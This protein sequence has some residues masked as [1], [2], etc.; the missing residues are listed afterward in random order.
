MH[1]ILKNAAVAPLDLGG[2]RGKSS[3]SK[4][5]SKVRASSE[6]KRQKPAMQELQTRLLAMMAPS[7]VN[8]Q[9][10]PANLRRQLQQKSAAD[11]IA[12]VQQE[13]RHRIPRASVVAV[14]GTPPFGEMADARNDEDAHSLRSEENLLSHRRSKTSNDG[15]VMGQEVSVAGS[16]V[17]QMTRAGTMMSGGQPSARDPYSSAPLGHLLSPKTASPRNAWEGGVSARRRMSV[18]L[19]TPLG[20]NRDASADGAGISPVRRKSI[21]GGMM[22]NEAQRDRWTAVFKKLQDEGEIHRDSLLVAMDLAGFPNCNQDQIDKIVLEITQYNTMNLKEFI[23]FVQTYEA[24]LEELYERD[25]RRFDADHS[26][27]LELQ[28]LAAFL[29]SSG[30][31]PIARILR[32]LMSEVAGPNATQISMMQFRSLDRIIRTREGWSMDD[33][34]SFKGLFRRF[35]KNQSG[36]MDTKELCHALRWLGYCRDTE[37][38]VAM[39]A[40]VDVDHSGALNLQELLVCMRKVRESEVNLIKELHNA[41]DR[42]EQGL[43]E[44]LT[45]LKALGY[46]PGRL[47]VREL[48]TDLDG[49]PDSELDFDFI[50]GVVEDFRRQEGFC[51][52]EYHELCKVF[53]EYDS[54]GC[55]NIETIDLNN[56]LRG[57]GY[58]T[59]W[60]LQQT[61]VAEVDIDNSGRIS[62]K[63]FMKIVSKH[64]EMYVRE[65]AMCYDSLHPDGNKVKVMSLRVAMEKS[66]IHWEECDLLFLRDDDAEID[67]FDLPDITT[68]IHKKA[69]EK[70]RTNAGFSKAEVEE[71]RASFVVFDKDSSG[72]INDGELRTL[73]QE[74]MPDKARD[75]SSRPAILKMLKEVD[76]NHDGRLDFGE[77]LRFMRQLR[78]LRE[79][80]VWA[81]EQRAIQRSLF[82]KEEVEDFRLLFLDRVKMR[83]A[84]HDDVREIRLSDIIKMFGKPGNLS[85]NDLQ[86]LAL[87][88]QAVTGVTRTKSATA[89]PGGAT[90]AQPVAGTKAAVK[91]AMKLLWE[92]VQLFAEQRLQ[93]EQSLDTLVTATRS[94]SAPVIG[95]TKSADFSAIRQALE[96]RRKSFNPP[97][98]PGPPKRGA[99][100][101]EFLL[102]MRRLIDLNFAGITGPAPAPEPQEHL[103]ES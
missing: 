56:V 76:V 97:T 14:D 62:K 21:A 55:G 6:G 92:E 33:M 73:I 70:F 90:V 82:S 52:E 48:I 60:D 31:T 80:Q 13:Q 86:L 46:F 100:F 36:D 78:N 26:G 42:I 93:D 40:E 19:D 30:I 77:F 79:G 74:L 39:A 91:S 18:K 34:E 87:E 81:K 45:I 12:E 24:R 67:V 50:W 75:P 41:P 89:Q 29:S 32:E 58:K 94:I 84:D 44:L 63:E 101:P 47:V 37:E 1:T 99:D 57:T 69:R 85:Q 9:R 38:I 98:M 59:S 20:S 16:A 5:S 88:F 3:P 4:P 51:T 22:I 43:E 15:D 49:D 53:D 11:F 8:L 66:G 96:R 23:N 68:R 71:F 17:T 7:S 102:L 25:F 27:L 35:D 103:P 65:L 83:E 64:H 95:K 10:N 2:C 61:L 72:D 54:V 28:E